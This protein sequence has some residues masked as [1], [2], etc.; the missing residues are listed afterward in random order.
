[1]ST[2]KINGAQQIKANSVGAAQVA[3]DVIIAAGSNAFSGNQ[4]MGGNKLTNLG[5]PTTGT[6]AA[7]KT[8]VD[9]AVTSLAEVIDINFDASGNPNYPAANKGDVVRIGT[10]GKIGGV[11]GVTVEVG[12]VALA[13]A[14]NAGGTQASVGASWTILQNN[15]VGALLASNNLSDLA[16][17]GTARTNLGLA[18]GTNVQSWDAD[19]DALAALS[20]TN[21]IYYRSAANTWTA[22]T[23]G[24]GL[25]FSGGSLTATAAPTFAT[26]ETPSGTVNGSNTDFTLAN[27]PTSGSESV[28]VNGVLQ[29]SGAGNDYT[30]ASAVITFLSGSVPQSGDKIR[31]SYRY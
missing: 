22:V 1:M 31:V 18:I 19:L 15:L 16:N 30:I 9:N 3:T 6:D 25:S 26:R 17:A 20:G 12:D 7:T 24:S 23:I 4:S 8:Y 5:T 14:D 11:S 10:A 28:F 13:L 29:D 2:T 27:T 21:T